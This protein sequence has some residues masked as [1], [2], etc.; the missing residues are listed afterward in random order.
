[1][2]GNSDW[3]PAKLGTLGRVASHPPGPPSCS[4]GQLAEEIAL[5]GRRLA[6]C[7]EFSRPASWRLLST[8]GPFVGV[9]VA[10]LQLAGAQLRGPLFRRRSME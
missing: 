5:S 2:L 10:L 3:P 1:M 7:L 4:Q 9:L 6:F 8:R